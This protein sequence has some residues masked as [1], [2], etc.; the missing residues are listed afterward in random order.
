[1]ASV[2]AISGTDLDDVQVSGAGR[3]KLRQKAS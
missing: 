1:M 2:A 3:A